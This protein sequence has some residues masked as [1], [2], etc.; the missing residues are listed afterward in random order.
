MGYQ[1][2]PSGPKGPLEEFKAILP[3]I[4]T[5]VL[6][7][8]FFASPLGGAFFA[9]TNTLFVLAFVRSRSTVLAGNI[10]CDEIVF[11]YDDCVHITE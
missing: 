4:G 11:A 7:G 6:I 5:A 2:P 8:L 9:I 3:T 10:Y 1:L